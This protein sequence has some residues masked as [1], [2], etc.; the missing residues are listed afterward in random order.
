M[1]INSGFEI[2][3]VLVAFALLG[4]ILIGTLITAMHLEQWHP[5]LVGAAV[6]ALL[7]FV[8]IETLPMLT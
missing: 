4:A 1:L 7:G 8:L 2:T 5:R 3:Y 6:G